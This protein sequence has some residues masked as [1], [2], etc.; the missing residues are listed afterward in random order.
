MAAV[1]QLGYAPNFNARALA[2]RQTHTIGAV[3]PTM[4]NAIF[5][6]GLQ[7]FQEELHRYGFTLL[8]ASSQYRPDVEAEQI[9]ALVARG[10]D[11]LLLIGY[12]RPDEIYEFLD[13]R[14]VPV[15]TAWAF[16]ADEERPAIGFD[17]RL[18]M[19]T[20]ADDVIAL[21]HRSIGCIS[22]RIDD[23]DRAR[24][25]V[26][27]VRQAMTEAGLDVEHLALVETE[28]SIDNGSAAFA[29]L[30]QC[31]DRPSVVICG[32]DVLA[33]G[34]LRAAQQMGL[35]VPDDISITGFDDIELARVVEPPL[36]TVHVPH[37]EMGREAAK[38]LVGLVNGNEA[39]ESRELSTTLC[40]RDTLGRPRLP[41][42]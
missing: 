17:N 38:T 24:E 11:A 22:A 9:R 20:L 30:L 41:S 4:D 26:E 5:A 6:R 36:T 3:I 35:R 34:A 40:L 23:N 2:A 12:Q 13:M 29:Q 28:Y 18:A 15:L 33:V 10:A 14:G 42:G 1:H 25:R 19:K 32:N 7:A 16:D 21:G 37:R 27:G 39:V 31:Q 8:V